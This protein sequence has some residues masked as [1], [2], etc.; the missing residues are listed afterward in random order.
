MIFHRIQQVLRYNAMQGNG[1]RNSLAF[2][3][4]TWRRSIIFGRV[5]TDAKEIEHVLDIYAEVYKEFSVWDSYIPWEQPEGI[6][7]QE[8]P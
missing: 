3:I 5:S 4:S 8:S 2:R 1:R 7:E 6:E